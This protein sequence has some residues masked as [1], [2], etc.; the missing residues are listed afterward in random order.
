MVRTLLLVSLFAAPL[1]AQAIVPAQPATP[2]P[3]PVRPVVPAR[4]PAT[5]PSP[6]ELHQ[7][8]YQFMLAGKFDKATP[9]LNRAYNETPAQGGRRG[10]SLVLNRANL[11]LVQRANP[12]RGIKDVYE[13]MA[14]ETGPD[15]EASNL[16][17]S[18]LDV[19]SRTPRLK[20]GPI[21]ADAFRE[22]ARR[23][24]TLERH[25]PGF[26]RWGAKWITEK[27]YDDIKARDK[28]LEI[29][30][31]E[32]AAVL[33]R[34]GENIKSTTVQYDSVY[35]QVQAYGRHGHSSGTGIG[36]G[37]GIVRR[38]PTINGLNETITNAYDCPYCRAM[39]DANQTARELYAE[40]Q[41]LANQQKR[42]QARYDEMK[43]R[44]TKPTWPARY[45]PVDPNAP[46]PKPPETPLPAGATAPVEPVVASQPES[47][48]ASQPTQQMELIR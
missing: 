35:K 36:T 16:L 8:A 15:E 7:Q 17:G 33:N 5:R 31:T 22:F 40:L 21:Y 20:D 38:T 13:Y 37:T 28:E 47:P 23:E 29:A 3:G 2:A 1:G 6:E 24:P 44:L 30:I 14:R 12:M 46:P 42:E 9:L 11:D 25:R 19:A 34:V 26:K 41:A 4:A 45:A 48:P 43:G 32:Q 39:N 18:L 27:E 10:R